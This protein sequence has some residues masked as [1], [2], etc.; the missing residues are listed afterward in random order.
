ME[1]AMCDCRKTLEESLLEKFVAEL[2]PE[3]RNVSVSLDGYALMFGS[4]TMSSAQFMRA[5]V[6]YQKPTKAG[7]LK[8]K[9][10]SANMLAK[11]CMFCGEK[12]PEAA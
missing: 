8:D 7:V 5:Q 6:T 3:C 4:G 2:G 1:I 11:F 10:T 9:K 12:Y